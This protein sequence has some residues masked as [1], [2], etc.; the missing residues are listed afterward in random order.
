VE[1]FEVPATT[2][3]HFDCSE[4]HPQMKKAGEKSKKIGTISW[5]YYKPEEKVLQL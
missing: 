4:V 1:G 2:T 5:K 3:G